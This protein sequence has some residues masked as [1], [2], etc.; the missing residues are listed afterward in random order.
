MIRNWITNLALKL[1]G[2][3]YIWGGST[4]AGFDCS[5]FVIWVLQVFNF[6]PT[7][8]WNAYQL[9]DLFSQTSDPQPGDLV[10]Y[11]DITATHVMMFWHKDT[12]NISYVVGASGGDHN[13]ITVEDANK[14]GA[15]VKVKRMDYRSDLLFSVDIS[16]PIKKGI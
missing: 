15:K 6:L 4:P 1:V 2:I 16:L 10:F 14:I 3:P 9:S 13:C 5:G 7:G 11:G 8:D 12:N